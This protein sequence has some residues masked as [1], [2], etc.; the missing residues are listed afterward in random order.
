MYLRPCRMCN[1]QKDCKA[2]K[3]M[4]R[5]LRKTGVTSAK[6]KCATFPELFKPGDRVSALL[7][8]RFEGHGTGNINGT[9]CLIKADKDAG[10][11]L[12]YL[13]EDPFE[14]SRNM[15]IRLWPKHLKL[16]DEPSRKVCE[17]CGIPEGVKNREGYC[18]CACDNPTEETGC[19]F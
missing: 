12:V 2:Y 9:V 8:E 15:F 6:F 13:D 4:L 11:V 7:S 1:R 3:E 14:D 17:C 19:P 18:C 10:K 5:R 16:I